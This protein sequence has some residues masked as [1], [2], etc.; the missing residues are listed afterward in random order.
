MK[1]VLLIISFLILSIFSTTI[2]IYAAQ[3]INIP[4]TNTW[5]YLEDNNKFATNKWLKIDYDN[6]GSYEYYYFD[7]NGYMLSNTITPDGY[8]VN[9]YGQW[10]VNGVI[11]TVQYATI[12]NKLDTTSQNINSSALQK[13]ELKNN[14]IKIDN[15]NYIDTTKVFNQ[16]WV[17]VIKFSGNNS[18]LKAN[19]GDYNRLEF[20]IGLKSYNEECEYKLSIFLDGKEIEIIDDIGDSPSDVS[21]DIDPNAELLMIYDCNT[22]GAYIS[23]DNKAL[24]MRNAKFKYVK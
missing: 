8:F 10:E 7:N 23:Q 17:N 18:Y 11:Q 13:K 6:D 3:W 4:N 5:C 21:I 12:S 24:Y 14:V 1:K 16:N 15:V 19:T 2:S 20:E 22:N 9:A